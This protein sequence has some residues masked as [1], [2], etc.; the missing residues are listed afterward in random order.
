M[1]TQ[2][3][4]RTIR[5]L[6]SAGLAVGGVFGMV[7]AFA[8]SDVLR[9]LAWGI[10]GM[11]LVVASAL[12]VILY[13]RKGQDII[14]AGFLVF[15]IGEGLILSGAALD[16]AASSPSFGAGTS[17]WAAALVLIS[18][19]KVFPPV[20]RILGFVAA[21]LFM[22]TAVQIFAG[23]PLL[24]TTEPLPFFAYPFFVATMFGWIWVLLKNRPGVQ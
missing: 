6:A 2:T 11:A 8:A 24:P 5:I 12:L 9:G 14:A 17:L 1:D 19:P 13:L 22:I 16:L 3:N 20:V 21:T 18:V 23:K 10:D 15:A 4:D 7:G